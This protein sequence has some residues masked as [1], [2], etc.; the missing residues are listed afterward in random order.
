MR[1]ADALGLF[2][3]GGLQI[4]HPSPS[5][6]LRGLQATYSGFITQGVERK[7]A[8]ETTPPKVGKHKKTTHLCYF[9]M[10]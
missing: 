8:Y 4:P 2:P 9:V 7:P 5:F 3:F 1:L 10:T 6:L